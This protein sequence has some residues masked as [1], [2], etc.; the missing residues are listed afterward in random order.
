MR[1]KRSGFAKKRKYVPKKPTKRRRSRVSSYEAQYNKLKAMRGYQPWHYPNFQQGPVPPPSVLRGSK[2]IYSYTPNRS[3]ASAAG[4]SQDVGMIITDG[5]TELID[6]IIQS[7]LASSTGFK[8][9]PL[10]QKKL[11]FNT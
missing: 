6:S 1:S 2:Q 3:I 11:N 8:P 9:T 5:G 10:K 7:R 4:K